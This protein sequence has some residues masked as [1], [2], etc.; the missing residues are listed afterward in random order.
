M[1]TTA[2]RDPVAERSRP[3]GGATRQRG[4]CLASPVLPVVAARDK[5]GLGFEV[6]EGQ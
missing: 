5:L 4:R 2:G 6:V 1:T 3:A